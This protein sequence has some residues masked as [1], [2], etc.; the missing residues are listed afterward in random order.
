MLQL[1]HLYVLC[2]VLSYYLKVLL[3]YLELCSISIGIW[4]YVKYW[5]VYFWVDLNAWRASEWLLELK[6]WLKDYI[7]D[8]KWCIHWCAFHIYW[9]ALLLKARLE[10]WL[11]Y[12]GASEDE[13]ASS[14]AEGVSCESD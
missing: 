11:G 1:V 5:S 7:H 6:A 3:V 8:G 13:G 9:W 14:E 4:I 12:E 2:M 10:D